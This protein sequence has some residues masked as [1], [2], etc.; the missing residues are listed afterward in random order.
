MAIWQDLEAKYYKPK[1]HFQTGCGEG[2]TTNSYS[3]ILLNFVSIHSTL[4][5]LEQD[6][7]LEHL[8]FEGSRPMENIHKFRDTAVLAVALYFVDNPVAHLW[9]IDEYISLVLKPQCQQFASL[10]AG[11]YLIKT[12]N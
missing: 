10:M 9:S 7:H 11:G 12:N 4:V 5:D 1:I 8:I 6:L 3:K 2:L